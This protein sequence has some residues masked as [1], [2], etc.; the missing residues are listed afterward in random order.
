MGHLR[1][2]RSD[3]CG[4]APQIT[5]FGHGQPVSKQVKIKR[6]FASG[7]AARDA[8]R[9]ALTASGKGEYAD[10]SKQP[11]GAYLAGWLDGL[12]LAPSTVASYRKNVRLHI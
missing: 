12:R 6:G 3:S 4:D 2:P 5:L 8:M 10:P 9:D 1:S 7:K 11:L